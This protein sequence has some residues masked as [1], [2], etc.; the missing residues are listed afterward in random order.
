MVTGEEHSTVITFDM[1][2][3]EKAVRLVDARED[4]KG[5]VLPRLG[6]L[7]TVMAALRALGKSIENSDDAWIEAVVYGL[8]TTRQILKCAHY[9]R[10][11]CAHILRYMALYELLLEKFFKKATLQIH[12][13]KTSE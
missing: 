1:A 4:L 10:S 11:L 9:K 13:L 8:A 2:L 6:E 5:T 7:H 3:Y 12:L